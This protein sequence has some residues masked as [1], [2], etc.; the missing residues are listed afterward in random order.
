MKKILWLQKK[1]AQLFPTMMDHVTE[2]WS[3]DAENAALHHKKLFN[4]ILKYIEIE[5][6]HNNIT[7]F[8]CIFDQV[9]AVLMSI[10]D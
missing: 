7:V 3:D 4:Y 8:F 6:H 5:N 1:A 10:R 2:A 9:N